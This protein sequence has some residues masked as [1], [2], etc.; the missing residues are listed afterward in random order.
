MKTK[1]KE[2]LE[3]YVNYLKRAG[4]IKSDFELKQ[5]KCKPTKI[6]KK[7]KRIMKLVPDNVDD[8]F[9]KKDRL[10]PFVG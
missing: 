3:K 6:D 8:D 5:I 1:N 10:L 2:K 9:T 7:L 4:V